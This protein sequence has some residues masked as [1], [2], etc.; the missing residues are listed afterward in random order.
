LSFAYQEK[1]S[2]TRSTVLRAVRVAAV[3]AIGAVGGVW[4]GWWIATACGWLPQAAVSVPAAIGGPFALT[5][6][7]GRAVTD[8]TFRGRWMLVFF[9]YTHCPDACPLA[10]SEMSETLDRLGPLADRVQP[11]FV[12][13]D[14]ER[15][16]PAALHDMLESFDPRIL[17][18]SG[19]QEQVAAAARAYHAFYAR[20]GD[21]P[22]Y[23]VDHST[24]LYVMDPQG[25]YVTH[26]THATGGDVVA[27]RLQ[28]LLAAAPSS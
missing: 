7:N 19:T 12:S 8:Q 24:L 18:L 22:D 3:A 17:G 9:G 15:D 26:F 2:M 6:M 16:T 1:L 20:H 27:Q 13:V 11:L 14:P 28:A 21:G 10:L 4:A 25:R 23:A 5:D